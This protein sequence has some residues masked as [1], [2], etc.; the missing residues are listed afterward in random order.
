LHVA[1]GGGVGGGVDAATAVDDVVAVA[2]LEHV[3]AGRAGKRYQADVGIGDDRAGAAGVVGVDTG[4]AVAVQRVGA[5]T[6]GNGVVADVAEQDIGVAVAG[7]AVVIDRA[8]EILEAVE[9]HQPLFGSLS[10]ALQQ[11]RHGDS[12]GGDVGL[13]G[14]EGQ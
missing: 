14:K 3:I 5:K 13:V 9:D 7:Q 8:R 1:G 6:A 10:C 11:Q 4:A 12:V 2:A